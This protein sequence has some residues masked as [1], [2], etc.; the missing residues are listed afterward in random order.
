MFGLRPAQLPLHH[1]A[2]AAAADDRGASVVV[3]SE[4][5]LRGRLG[6]L[7]FLAQGVVAGDVGPQRER[8]GL[9]LLQTGEEDEV[10]FGALLVGAEGVA[11][12][13]A[14]HVGFE[15][16]R[17]GPLRDLSRAVRPPGRGGAD[18]RH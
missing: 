15:I 8:V 13:D 18:S 4:G 12:L 16:L 7:R 10:G 1:R 5:R 6:A 11:E 3:H 2:V 9:A 14:Q 17:H